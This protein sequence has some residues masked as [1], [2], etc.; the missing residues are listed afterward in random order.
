MNMDINSRKHGYGHEYGHGPLLD[1]LKLK[2]SV[3]RLIR[4]LTVFTTNNGSGSY[5]ST[6]STISK[7]RMSVQRYEDEGLPE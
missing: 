3:I 5:L 6:K 4:G 1:I 2:I 7:S